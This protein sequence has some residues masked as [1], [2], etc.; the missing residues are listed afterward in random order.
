[1]SERACKRLD[2]LRSDYLRIIGGN[3][4][5]ETRKPNIASRYAMVYPAGSGWIGPRA[6]A[7]FGGNIGLHE[8]FTSSG[9]GGG[10]LPS[11]K[12]P[13]REGRD[14]HTEI[15][16]RTVPNLSNNRLIR[17]AQRWLYRVAYGENP[18]ETDYLR[19][20][21]LESDMFPIYPKRRALQ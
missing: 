2:N 5:V 8:G 4:R 15:G 9:T 1:M 20:F 16:T 17:K 11:S 13:G 18:E 10:G 7:D 14:S 21:P 6:I 19:D 12:P 3:S